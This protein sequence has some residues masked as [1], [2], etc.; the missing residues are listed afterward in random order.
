MLQFSMRRAHMALQKVAGIS[1]PKGRKL[2]DPKANAT[3]RAVA[4]DLDQCAV[5]AW[6]NPPGK[7]PATGFRR[8]L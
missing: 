8:G 3:S 5:M 2:L 1:P 7:K 6:G 4:L